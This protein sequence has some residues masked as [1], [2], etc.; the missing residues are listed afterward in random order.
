[1]N[2]RPY[3]REVRKSIE[4]DESIWELG[5]CMIQYGPPKISYVVHYREMFENFKDFPCKIC[6]APSER[7]IREDK[8]DFREQR[9]PTY[10]CEGCFSLII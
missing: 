5:R 2:T 7:A 9:N 8:I 4:P 6:G 3:I 10:L 1:M